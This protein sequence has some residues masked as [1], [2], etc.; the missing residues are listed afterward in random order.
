MG[1]RCAESGKERPGAVYPVSYTHLDVYKRQ[2]QVEGREVP[3]KVQGV[4]RDSLESA[5]EDGANYDDA[6]SWGEQQLEK[7]FVV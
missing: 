3:E 1:A 2:A 4:I 7:Y 6:K 5:F